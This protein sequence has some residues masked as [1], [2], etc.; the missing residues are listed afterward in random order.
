MVLSSDAHAPA[1]Q[2]LQS[3]THYFLVFFYRR[4]GYLFVGGQ[5]HEFSA[6]EFATN[7]C[8]IRKCEVESWDGNDIDMVCMICGEDPNALA[9]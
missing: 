7:Q 8:R 9:C 4:L 3:G 1:N 5:W 6:G 2:L